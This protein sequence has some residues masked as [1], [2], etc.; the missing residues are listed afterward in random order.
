M[1]GYY[2]ADVNST[3][4]VRNTTGDAP[5]GSMISRAAFTIFTN[6]AIPGSHDAWDYVIN[7]SG[8]AQNRYLICSYDRSICTYNLESGLGENG[9]TAWGLGTVALNDGSNYVVEGSIIPLLTVDAFGHYT[10]I[11]PS[12]ASAGASQLT[13]EGNFVG[14]DG[15]VYGV[16]YVDEDGNINIPD[17]HRVKMDDG[18]YGYVSEAEL[19]LALFNYATTAEGRQDAIEDI[20]DL[21]A[22]AFKQAFAEYFGID[23]LSIAA[24]RECVCEMRYA[25]GLNNAL[26]A[27]EEDTRVEL[28][29]GIEG[30][31]VSKEKAAGVVSA[32]SAAR[33][34]GL[35]ASDLAGDI[36]PEDISITPEVL[37][38]LHDIA[39]PA[40]AVTVPVYAE[41]GTTIIGERSF[42]RL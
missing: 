38:A 15:L 37:A 35:E 41:D 12:S 5:A 24:A 30:G 32:S 11:V 8:T 34:S 39:R 6:D 25:D 1:Y 17:M 9:A 23:A 3:M 19:N 4:Y 7:T 26:S 27:I 33:S 20:L 22:Q 31:T 13:G 36:E 40:L 29:A 18:G 42:N 21:E 28:S 14:N 2:N 10:S 16:A